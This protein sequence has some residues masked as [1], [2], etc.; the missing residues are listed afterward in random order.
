MD[1]QCLAVVSAREVGVLSEEGGHGPEMP[2]RMTHLPDIDDALTVFGVPGMDCPR[3]R[4]AVTVS[5]VHP[6]PVIRTAPSD[7]G[8]GRDAN[9]SSPESCQP[10]T[11]RPDGSLRTITR[12]LYRRKV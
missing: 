11:F 6:G 7:G 4:P 3:I 2:E 9:G 10:P 1:R 5:D 12:S 8:A